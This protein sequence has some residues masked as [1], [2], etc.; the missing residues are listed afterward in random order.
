VEA[1]PQARFGKHAAPPLA[2]SR[3]LMML[4]RAAVWAIRASFG[5]MT[6][7]K[8]LPHGRLPDAAR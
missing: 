4:M 6:C 3:R 7:R 1:L 8:L 5:N 2:H